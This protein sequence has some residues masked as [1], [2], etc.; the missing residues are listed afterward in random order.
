M[1]LGM[2]RYSDLGKLFVILDF[3][4]RDGEDGKGNS[5]VYMSGD[6]GVKVSVLL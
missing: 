1:G 3:E 5:R 4:C 6:C 2:G